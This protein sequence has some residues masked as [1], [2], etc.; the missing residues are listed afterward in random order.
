MEVSILQE[1][2]KFKGRLVLYRKTEE[3]ISKNTEIELKGDNFWV[4]DKQIRHLYCKLSDISHTFIFSE[5]FYS[6]SELSLFSFLCFL[7]F[8]FFFVLVAFQYFFFS[9][10]HLCFT[11][12]SF[13]LFFLMVLA[14]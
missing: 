8:I 13:P 3:T 1:P 12:I 10:Y 14:S 5:V 11:M 4:R 2:V 6:V 7:F 9:F